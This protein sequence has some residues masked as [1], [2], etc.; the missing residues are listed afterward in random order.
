MICFVE[1]IF[2]VYAMMVKIL[3]PRAEFDS[4]DAAD[5]LALCQCAHR[6]NVNESYYAKVAV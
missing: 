4:S 2:D 6:R 3:L 1:Y 5:A